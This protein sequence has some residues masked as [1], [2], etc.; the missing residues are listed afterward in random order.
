MGCYCNKLGGMVP[1]A[2]KWESKAR[3]ALVGLFR[4]F[5]SVVI[6]PS[7]ALMSV[8]VTMDMKLLRDLILYFTL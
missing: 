8:R 7:V 1:S 3:L 4:L 5:S 6:H 2:G